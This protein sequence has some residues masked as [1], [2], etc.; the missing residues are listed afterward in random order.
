MSTVGSEI[1]H[2]TESYTRLCCPSTSPIEYPDV[3]DV[4]APVSTLFGTTFSFLPDD[5]LVHPR[6]QIPNS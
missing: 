4:P 2:P 3:L 6:R 5:R 1:G